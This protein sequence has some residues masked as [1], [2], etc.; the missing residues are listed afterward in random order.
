[1]KKIRIGN[2]SAFSALTPLLPF[3]YAVANGF[4]AFEWFPDRHESGQ[5]WDESDIDAETRS[6]IRDTA[7]THDIALSVHASLKSNPL[8]A[9]THGIIL[10]DIEFASDIGAGLLNIH[11]DAGSGIE[12]Y[13]EAITPIIAYTKKAGIRLSIE[14]TVFASPEDFNNVFGLLRKLKIS[15]KKDVGMCLDLGHANLSEESRND[16]MRFLD[17]LEPNVPIIHIHMHENYGDSDSHLPLFRG[18]AGTDMS[19]ICLFIKRMKKRRFAG[20]IIF[21]Q[22]PEPPLLLNEARDRLSH[23]WN[24]KC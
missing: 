14:N 11:L 19:G 23:M 18:P 6:Y 9:E 2:Q 24:E 1:M 7:R 8:H 13:V 20:S 16:Y 21:E 4:N 10:K 12:N 5:G 3:E 17:Q 15:A 22:W